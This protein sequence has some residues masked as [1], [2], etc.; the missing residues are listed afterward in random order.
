M[1]LVKKLLFGVG[2]LALLSIALLVI[3]LS[4]G[5]VL[6]ECSEEIIFSAQSPS[7]KQYAVIFEKDC[8]ATTAISTHLGLSSTSDIP[9]E[10]ILIIENSE[11]IKAVW[12]DAKTLKVTYTAKDIDSIFRQERLVDD[13]SVVYGLED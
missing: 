7:G 8:G 6:G 12:N 9:E 13:I 3:F 2:T 1:K 5:G 4:T 11:P 10:S